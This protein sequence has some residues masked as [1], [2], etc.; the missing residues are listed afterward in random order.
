MEHHRFARMAGPA[1]DSTS[2]HH[3]GSEQDRGHAPHAASRMLMRL[4]AAF[5]L[6]VGALTSPAHAQ[7]PNLGTAADFAVL[8]GSTVTNT[9]SSVLLGS[10]GV[11]PGSAITGFPPGI[12][13]AP[14][15]T[16]AADAVA[17]QAQVDLVIGYNT[18]SSR[19]TTR[20]LTGQN[21]GGLTL[22]PGVYNFSSSAQLTGNLTLNALGNPNAVFIFN[23]GSTLT[24]G[25]SSSVTVIGGGLGS[26]VYWRVGS[27]A[28]LGTTTSFVGDILALTSITLNTGANISCG[29]ALAR[30]G[31][32]TLDTNAIATRNLSACAVAPLLPVTPVVVPPVVVPPGVV[33]VVIPPGVVVPPGAVPVVIP[34]GVVVPP[35]AVP[36]VLPPGVVVAPGAVPVVIPPGV[37]VPPGAIP[38]IVVVPPA[39]TPTVVVAP[40][41]VVTGINTAF[42]NA[43]VNNNNTVPASFPQAFLNLAALSPDAQANALVQ[44]SGEAGTGIA[45]AGIQAMNSFL[46]L[47]LNPFADQFAESRSGF[48]APPQAVRTLGFAPEGP[49]NLVT[50]Y[51]SIDKAPVSPTFDRRQWGVWAATYG[52]QNRT[53]GDPIVGTHDRIARAFG[54]ATGFDYRVTPDTVVGFAL[55]G[56]GTNYGLSD[57]LGGGHSDMF[58]AAVYSST[59]F[60]AAYVSAALAYAFHRASTDRWLAVAG[61]DHLTS[62]F[63]AQNIGGRIEG[64]YRFAVPGAFGLSGFGF[65]P[66]AAAQAQS[67]R[68]P[69]FSEVAA[70]GSA[71]FALD[72]QAHTATAIRTELGAWLDQSVALDDRTVLT[73]RA[74]AAWAHDRFSDPTTIAVF[75][76]VPD[77]LFTVTGAKPVT[78]SALLSAGAWL[79]FAYGLSVG[80]RFDSEF[81][82]RSQTYA[83]TGVVRY[84]W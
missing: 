14:G 41:P 25:S 55:A 64:G 11:S 59:R 70:S 15:S 8:A 13:L 7:A 63:S 23:V 58:Q 33:P 73:L 26:N 50:A 27:S 18:L 84:M 82:G 35:G 3:S 39:T 20:D 9:G 32:V 42:R 68:T 69:S 17:V 1:A 79:R 4:T 5:G 34:P 21:L 83:G 81:A 45:L 44:L 51:A 57:N 65:T 28:T 40:T 75:Q 52:A 12:V 38:A 72:Y 43:V 6:I 48:G 76:A 19:P 2:T 29:S 16:H 37:V 74:R 62:D 80:A 47:V 10:L 31:A 22:T 60:N 24:T 78:D 56:G 46:A 53:S 36:V 54:V 77:A 67:F 30:N 61:S 66:Y 71:Q 49:T